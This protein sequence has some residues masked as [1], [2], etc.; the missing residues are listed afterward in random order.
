MKLVFSTI[1][2]VKETTPDF[3]PLATIPVF[4]E[5]THKGVEFIDEKEFETLSLSVELR[6]Y[7]EDKI[8]SDNMGI[9][10]VNSAF[11]INNNSTKLYTIL[12]IPFF[13]TWVNMELKLNKNFMENVEESIKQDYLRR[14]KQRYLKIIEDV[15]GADLFNKI[16]DYTTAMIEK[17]IGLI[18]DQTLKQKR[19]SVIEEYKKFKKHFDN[20]F[21]KDR[22]ESKKND[23]YGAGDLFDDLR[24]RVFGTNQVVVPLN[25][26]LEIVLNL[27]IQKK[28]Q[29]KIE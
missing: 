18:T 23:G 8:S 6:D 27:K 2:N 1:N 19:N 15:F 21:W 9:I 28:I 7:L 14:I 5:R 16:T 4:G 25:N 10:D 24:D 3:D 22:R 11:Y 12:H 20:K 17:D 13:I 29:K 26:D